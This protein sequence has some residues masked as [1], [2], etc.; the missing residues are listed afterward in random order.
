MPAPNVGL[1]PT[2]RRLRVSCS[3]DWA[4][5]ARHAFS[6][7]LNL[8]LVASTSIK[9]NIQASHRFL[10][11]QVMKTFLIFTPLRIWPQSFFNNPSHKRPRH[12]DRQEQS[13]KLL[14]DGH[15]QLHLLWHISVMS[16]NKS[17]KI[18]FCSYSA[19]AF[20]RETWLLA[21]FCER[22]SYSC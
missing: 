19:F 7:N 22:E 6:D 8:N 5:R 4:S 14:K 10:L 16:G 9:I 15:V 21:F 18:H 1:E 11:I 2:T 17:V 12:A 13:L 3:T 20:L